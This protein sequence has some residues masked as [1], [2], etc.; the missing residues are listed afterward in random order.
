MFSAI[1][2]SSFSSCALV[3]GVAVNVYNQSENKGLDRLEDGENSMIV[4][5]FVMNLQCMKVSKV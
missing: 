1:S 4:G 3:V 5:E 2:L